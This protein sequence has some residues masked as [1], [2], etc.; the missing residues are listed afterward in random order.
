MAPPRARSPIGV[1]V[2]GAGARCP[3]RFRCQL[4]TLVRVASPSVWISNVPRGASSIV[5]G[6]VAITT[7]KR[8]THL[9]PGEGSVNKQSSTCRKPRFHALFCV[10]KNDVYEKD[11]RLD[12]PAVPPCPCHRIVVLLLQLPQSGT[13]ADELAAVARH[14]GFTSAM[15]ALLNSLLS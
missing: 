6:N 3:R 10:G 7:S 14:R 1:F 15:H 9:P 4:C 2:V 8:L 12:I 5:G 13:T 11:L